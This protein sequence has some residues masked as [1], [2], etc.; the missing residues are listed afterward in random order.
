MVEKSNTV[1]RKPT[2][3]S[4][5]PATTLGSALPRVDSV[6]H[7]VEA[8]LDAGVGIDELARVAGDTARHLEAVAAVGLEAAV[9]DVAGDIGDDLAPRRRRAARGDEVPL[10]LVVL[11]LVV[12][13]APTFDCDAVERRRV[14]VGR[15]GREQRVRQRAVGVHDH[16]CGGDARI[17]D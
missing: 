5:S 16:A 11:R 3:I 4:G 8:E 15:R 17:D 6:D 9:A 13:V 2:T 7:R 10:R 1:L 12:V 14:P